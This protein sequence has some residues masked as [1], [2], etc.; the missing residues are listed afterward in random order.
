METPSKPRTSKLWLYIAWG[1][2]LLIVIAYSIYWFVARSM[3]SDSID[4]W[5]ESEKERG[6]VVEYSD[7][8]LGGFPFRFALSLE[9]PIY[10]TPDGQRWEGD[11]LQLVMQPWNWNHI[12]ARAPGRNVVSSETGL[13]HTVNLGKK[14]AGSVSWSKTGIRR[15]GLQ[16]DEMDALI[17]GDEISAANFSLNLAPRS[18]APNDLRIAVQWDELV[19]PEAPAGAEFLGDTLQAS[20]MI[21]DIEGFFP[22]YAAAG[23]DVS[24]LPQALLTSEAHIYL[25]SLFLNWGALK[26]GAKGDISA[27]KQA[28]NGEISVRIDDAETLRGAMDAAGQAPET[29][30][31]ITALEAASKDGKFLTLT[32]RDNQILFLGQPVATLIPPSG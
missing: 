16:L 18:G 6:A 5:L 11:Q 30:M 10:Q 20:R 13:R 32:V 1:L 2:F 27:A 15:I 23:G 24:A 9:D 19:L 22:A 4:T 14:S 3:V 26:L 28:W 12:I 7:R 31:G 17:A 25:G 8:S 29:M 21:A